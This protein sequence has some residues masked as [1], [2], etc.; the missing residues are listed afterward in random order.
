M[1]KTATCQWLLH[2]HDEDRDKRRIVCGK[3]AAGKVTVRTKITNARVDVCSGH[4]QEHNVLY[5]QLRVAKQAEAV[6]Q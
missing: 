3:P 5:S 2:P 6:A 1:V 4:Q